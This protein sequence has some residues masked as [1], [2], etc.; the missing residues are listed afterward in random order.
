VNHR[1]AVLVLYCGPDPIPERTMSLRAL[2][3][4]TAAALALAAGPAHA[5]PAKATAPAKPA[6]PAAC[7]GTLSG[8]H[9]ATF[10]CGVVVR[11]LGD[12]T[13]VIEFALDGSL[14]GIHSFSPGGWIIPGTPA[15]GTYPFSA[16]GQGR[17]GLILEADGTL[18]S[19]QRTY[20]ERGEVSLTFTKVKR[21]T[22]APGTYEVSGS[23]TAKL[24]ASASK[25]TDAIT[26]QV[27]F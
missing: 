17:S 9:Q 14:D 11:D 13:A 27:K 23:F 4:F 10:K 26:V 15:K 19:A 8:A 6:G 12:G 7:T 21:S 5:E 20:Q 25:R 3:L 22:V 1:A 18:F 16:L 24:P 2:T